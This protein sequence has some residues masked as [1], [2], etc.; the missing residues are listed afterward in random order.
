[1][2][3]YLWALVVVGIGLTLLAAAREL[4]A[5]ARAVGVEGSAALRMPVLFGAGY[6]SCPI[7]G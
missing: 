4:R 5:S 7:R 1:M 6:E 3:W 2:P